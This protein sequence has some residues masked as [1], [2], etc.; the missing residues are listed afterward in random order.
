MAI[1]LKIGEKLVR[2]V[3]VY[4]PHI[5][6]GWQA[7]HQCFEDL[8][9]L[10]MQAQDQGMHVIIGG[11]FNL[12]LD[13]SMR[14][15]V[16]REFCHQF[17]MV[18]ANGS[19]CDGDDDVY[20]FISSIGTR[21]RIDYILISAI[22]ELQDIKASN[23]LDLGSDHRCIYASIKFKRPTRQ[24]KARTPNLKGW[25]P[26]LNPDKIPEKYHEA[27]QHEM[28]VQSV[29]GMKEIGDVCIRA[30]QRPGVSDDQSMKVKRPHQSDELKSLIQQRRHSSG[31]DRRRLSQQIY[32]V[33]RRELRAW[34]T[35]WSEFLLARMRGTRRLQKL[36]EEPIS[37]SSCPIE[38]DTFAEFLEKIFNKDKEKS[39]F[40][41]PSLIAQI[42]LF[43]MVELGQALSNLANLRACDVDGC[44]VELFKW[45]NEDV[46]LE[47]L[48]CFNQILRYGRIDDS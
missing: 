28:S 4:M 9:N 33:S 12:N 6:Y 44:I 37:S 36:T 24:L 5:G 10:L 14:G 7:F 11:D 17:S 29:I 35:K 18:I 46:K 31:A 30:A 20:S 40:T 38:G 8:S 21:R 47:M 25:R 13:D 27:L 15:S 48:S 32:K 1:D 43:S 34:R 22:W 19:G 16:M 23:I 26:V 41:D 3:S 45:A 39:F 2:V 42:P